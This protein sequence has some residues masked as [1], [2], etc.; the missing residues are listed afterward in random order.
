LTDWIIYSIVF[1]VDAANKCI[2]NAR[3]A[4]GWSTTLPRLGSRVRIPSRALNEKPE[5]LILQGFPAFFYSCF[6]GSCDKHATKFDARNI[7][8]RTEVFFGII[9]G[10]HL[11][12]LHRM[13]YNS[14]HKNMVHHDS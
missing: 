14:G 2:K 3:V 11:A 5:I 6:L 7:S 1:I 8:C 4:Q 9:S 13:G 10:G 12:K